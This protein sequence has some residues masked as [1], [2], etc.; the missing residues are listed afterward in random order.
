MDHLL[1]QAMVELEL[2]GHHQDPPQQALSMDRLLLV[3]LNLAID[4][5]PDPPHKMTMVHLLPL[6]NLNPTLA[7]VL[8]TRSTE[9]HLPLQSAVP[10]PVME[11]ELELLR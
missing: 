5:H 2:E 10:N 11:L 1:N 4:H 7:G 9:L 6:Y 3:I 8:Q